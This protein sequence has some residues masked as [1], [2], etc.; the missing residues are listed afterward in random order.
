VDM[1]FLRC[2]HS[3]WGKGLKCELCGVEWSGVEWSV[4]DTGHETI[5]RVE[6]YTCWLPLLFPI[7][8]LFFLGA[9]NAPAFFS[10]DCVSSML[11]TVITLVNVAALN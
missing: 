6:N 5:T 8:S 11:C 9:T 10:R 2:T 4:S 7:P 3:S 1:G